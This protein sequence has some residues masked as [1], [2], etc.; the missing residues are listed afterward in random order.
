MRVDNSTGKG[1]SGRKKFSSIVCR[2]HMDIGGKLLDS[3]RSKVQSF[4]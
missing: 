2:V 3:L 1:A 4:E